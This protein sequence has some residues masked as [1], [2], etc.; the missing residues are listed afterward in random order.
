VGSRYLSRTSYNH[1]ELFSVGPAIAP[2]GTLT[3]T[4]APNA[5]GSARIKVVLHD[6]GA[7][8]DDG[9]DTSA[10]QTFVISVAPQ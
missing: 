10:P 3:F 6:S 2:D 9:V 8:A 4:P 7:V 5:N 1:P